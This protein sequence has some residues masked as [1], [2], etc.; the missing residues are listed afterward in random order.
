MNMNLCSTLDIFSTLC[1]LTSDNFGP[2][3]STAINLIFVL[4]VVI[5][6]LY[7]IFGGIK[8]I[9]SRGNKEEVESA[10]NHI[11]ASVVGLI[12]VFLAFFCIPCLNPL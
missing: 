6:V 8:W 12:V 1:N 4:A 10:R 2:V 5:A 9:M 7:L 11:V 3:V